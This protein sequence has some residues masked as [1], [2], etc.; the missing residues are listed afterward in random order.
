MDCAGI[1]LIHEG[2]EPAAPPAGEKA[3]FLEI[4]PSVLSYALINGK[5]L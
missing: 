1:D 4:D 2:D 3:K 5:S